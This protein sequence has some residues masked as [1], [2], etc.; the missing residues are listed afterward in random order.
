MNKIFRRLNVTRTLLILC[1]LAL[2]GCDKC[3]S[4]VTVKTLDLSPTRHG[5]AAPGIK[6]TQGLCIGVDA[7]P[8]TSFSPG[9]GQIMVGFDNFFDG[10]TFCDR[11]RAQVFRGVI[12]FD[13]SQ[14]DSIV[15][16]NLI[17][18]VQRSIERIN[19]TVAQN[20]AKSFAT[21]L[22]LATPPLTGKLL[23]DTDAPLSGGPSFDVGVTGQ[24]KSWV[25]K[26]H[27]A[28]GFV[29][30][31]PTGLVDPGNPPENN[32]AKVSWYGNFKLRV[33]YNPGLNPR[34]PQ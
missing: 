21:T 7:P 3:P 17:F 22:G 31:G 28:S 1:A 25:D 5:Q 13:V 30:A 16:A 23:F 34:A 19:E 18:D 33:V 26:S 32:E 2:A 29:L 9:T 10:G 27:P 8:S 4:P 20:P 12:E 15:G 14:F 24:V 6:G 11:I